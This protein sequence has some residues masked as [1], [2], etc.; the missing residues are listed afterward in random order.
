MTDERTARGGVGWI[1]F[2]LAVS[3]AAPVAGYAVVRNA[4]MEA[5]GNLGD[6]TT[7]LPPASVLSRMKAVMRASRRMQDD[8]PPGA[9][10]VARRA[11]V[12]LPL[13]YEPYFILARAEE[14]A[15]R[16]DRATRLMEEARRR[17]PNSTSVHV[18]L[19][20]YYSLAE[21][22]QKAI[23]EAD[24]AMR[25][26]G[27]S[28]SLI[29]P[30]FAKLVA[31][32]PKARQAIAVS[33]ARRPPWRGAFL[34][35]AATSKMDAASARALVSDIRR[36]A[37]SRVPQEEE[38]FLIRALV[39]SGEYREARALWESF[40]PASLRTTAVTDGDFKGVTT[41]APFKWNLHSGADGSAE[42]AK[43]SADARAHLEVDY[44]GGAPLVLADQTLAA[45]P[46]NY[47]LTSLLTGEGEPSDVELNWEL[48]CLPSYKTIATLKLRPFG[49][50]VHRRETAVTIPASG[51]TGQAL[52]LIGRTGEVA[53]PVHAEI[54]NIALT[55]VGAARR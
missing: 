5:A 55:P 10:A 45:K 23:D 46:G 11:A 21:A 19:L 30:G 14:K 38:A 18:A 8:L 52:G 50:G 43:P 33:L 34:E 35:V 20:G 49:S 28:M 51:C 17:R 2:A 32:D 4:A 41:L 12:E 40:T 47:R 29:L 48:S 54:R 31:A 42:A 53:R 9:V 22:Y 25:V 7:R 44:F 16:Y 24:M 3:L 27:R 13:A 6:P 37:P 1:V 26:N 36:L 15:G 39:A